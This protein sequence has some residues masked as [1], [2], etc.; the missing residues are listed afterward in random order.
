MIEAPKT[1][2]E[3]VQ[4]FNGN[5]GRVGISRH[6]SDVRSVQGGGQ[7]FSTDGNGNLQKSELIQRRQPQKSTIQLFAAAYIL[8]H[9]HCT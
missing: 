4:Q 7:C 3:A 6:S 1:H 5:W 2:E 9:R 8:K